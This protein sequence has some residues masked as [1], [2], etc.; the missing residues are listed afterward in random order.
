[1]VHHKQQQASLSSQS[2]FTIIESLVAI[3]VVAILLTAIAPVIVLSVATRVQAKRIETATDA[4]KSYIDGVRSGTITAPNSPIT[5]STDIAAYAAPTAGSLTCTANAYCTSPA[6]NLYCV[7]LDGNNCTTTSTN[8]FV[9]QAIR[10]NKATVTSGG[11]TTNIVDPTKGYQLG[12]RVYRADGFSS[13][14]GV[15]KNAPSKQ[16]TF[17]GGGGDRKTPLVEITTEIT[18]GVTFS[19][20]CDRLRQPSPTPSPSPAPP[21]QS[22]CS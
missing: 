10:Y 14:G 1:M 3:L 15:L 20:F 5:N 4:A 16:P 13:D 8:N 17:T 9:I 11:T 7:S 22:Q 6:N 2:G 21:A 19:D 12:I 18:K